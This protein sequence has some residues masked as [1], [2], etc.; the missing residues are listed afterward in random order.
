MR[1]LRQQK[2]L[3]TSMRKKAVQ[4]LKQSQQDLTR[5]S[6]K[7]VYLKANYDKE[8]GEGKKKGIGA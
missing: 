3:T 7:R 5:Q 4:E 2:E 8:S 1:S 6:R